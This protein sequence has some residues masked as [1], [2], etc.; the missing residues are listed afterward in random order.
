MHK[1]ASKGR[2]WYRN[3]L[4]SSLFVSLGKR[5]A[6]PSA[7]HARIHSMLHREAKTDAKRL[8]LRTWCPLCGSWTAGGMMFYLVTKVFYH[9]FI[10]INVL[11]VWFYSSWNL[12]SHFFFLDIIWEYISCNCWGYS[13]YAKHVKDNFHGNNAEKISKQCL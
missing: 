9:S 5:N 4:F 7:G 11:W 13:L 6:K 12:F 1:V 8:S 3:S 10:F 2:S